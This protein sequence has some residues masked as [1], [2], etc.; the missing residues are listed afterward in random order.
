MPIRL[1]NIRYTEAT[2]RQVLQHAV[3]QSP[4]RL[5]QKLHGKLFQLPALLIL[6]PVALPR[7]TVSSLLLAQPPN[8][9]PTPT[10]ATLTSH[11]AI[12]SNINLFYKAYAIITV[13]KTLREAS[14]CQDEYI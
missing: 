11:S 12:D 2:Q 5:D 9:T 8:K 10:S 3:Q 6:Q 13:V 7:A 1:F 4:Y 14:F